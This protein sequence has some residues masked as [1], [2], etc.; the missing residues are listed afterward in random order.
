[1]ELPNR[2]IGQ[3][4]LPKAAFFFVYDYWLYDEGA[5]TFKSLSDGSVMPD[6]LLARLAED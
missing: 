3:S 1:M 4:L 2:L 5:E 6:E